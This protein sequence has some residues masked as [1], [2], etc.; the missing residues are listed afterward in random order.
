M[1]LNYC[2]EEEILGT[3]TV[4]AVFEEYWNRDTFFDAIIRH[5]SS[6]AYKKNMYYEDD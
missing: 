4:I 1:Q 2:I 3:W 5:T 6:R